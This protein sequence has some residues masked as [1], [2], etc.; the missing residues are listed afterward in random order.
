MEETRSVVR[1]LIDNPNGNK[2]K[3][4]DFKDSTK[5]HSFIKIKTVQDNSCLF[6][7][8][9]TCVCPEYQENPEHRTKIMHDFRKSILSYLRASD[10]DKPPE[11]VYESYKK[12]MGELNGTAVK[13]YDQANVKKD[14]TQAKVIAGSSTYRDAFNWSKSRRELYSGNSRMF[15]LNKD[16]LVKGIIGRMREVAFRESPDEDI[17]NMRLD[18]IERNILNTDNFCD[19]SVKEIIENVLDINILVFV[20]KG[21]IMTVAYG[22]RNLKI[23]KPLVIIFNTGNGIFQAGGMKIKKNNHVQTIFH[24]GSD[25]YDKIKTIYQNYTKDEKFSKYRTF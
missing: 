19:N 22:E 17:R 2:A 6:H 9:L 16:I 11:L 24:P 7:S 12:F 13:M 21:K 8:L 3:L 23:N 14:L 25:N 5:Y 18:K 20:M 10:T 1:I 15:V 4:K